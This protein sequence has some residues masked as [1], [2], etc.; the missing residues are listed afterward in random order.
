IWPL[1]DAADL[2]GGLF[3]PKDGQ[4]NPVDTARALAKGARMRGAT[5][6]EGVKVTGFLR[7]GR[8]I[9]HVR[10]TAGDVEAEYVVNCA[11][12]WGREIGQMAG[13]SVSLDVG[14]QFFVVIGT[15]A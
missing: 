12:M 9:T 6:V 15:L 13:A 8:R 14:T 11:G 7:Q 1:I 5:I 10:T 3:I 4:T 2:V